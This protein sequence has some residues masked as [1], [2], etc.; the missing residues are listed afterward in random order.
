[1]K[2]NH[3]FFSTPIR[4][5][6]SAVQQLV[7]ENPGEFGRMVAELHGQIQGQDGRFTISDESRNLDLSKVAYIVIDPFSVSCNSKEIIAGLHKSV[8]NELECGEDFLEIRSVLSQLTNTIMKTSLKI[9][10]NSYSDEMTVQSVLKALSLSLI[11][12]CSISEKI[13]EYVR[14][15]SEYCLKR[16]AIIV[17]IGKFLSEDEYSTMI[18]QMMYNQ[19][20]VLLIENQINRKLP[21]KIIDSD[22]CEMDISPPRNLFEV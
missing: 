14:L 17:D 20:P 4:F 3:Y 7:I 15:M 22:L 12:P 16:L 1:M 18:N 5:D 11:E 10:S 2:L 9:E 8:V 21:S 13:C 19:R 6:D